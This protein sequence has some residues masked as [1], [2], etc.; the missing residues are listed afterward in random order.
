[1]NSLEVLLNALHHFSVRHAVYPVDQLPRVWTKSITIVA[2]TDNHDRHGQHWVA[3]YIDEYIHI[4]IATFCYPWTQDSS[5]DFAETSPSIAGIRR[6][7]KEYFLKL[8]VNTAVYFYILCVIVII[9]ASFSVCLP[10]IR[11]V[12]ID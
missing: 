6:R 12:M 7:C 8:G 10:L 5:Y 3:F 4:S 2:N 11:N 1:M 9:L